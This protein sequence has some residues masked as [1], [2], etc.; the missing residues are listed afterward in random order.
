M[1][2]HYIACNFYFFSQ[3]GRCLRGVPLEAGFLYGK[4]KVVAE[5]IKEIPGT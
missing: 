3:H 1:N 2:L 5:N 4:D